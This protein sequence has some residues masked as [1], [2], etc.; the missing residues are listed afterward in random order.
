MHGYCV[1]K[2]RNGYALD[3]DETHRQSVVCNAQAKR[4]HVV[5]GCG[6]ESYAERRVVMHC[7]KMQRN[8][9]EMISTGDA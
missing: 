4:G 1:D 8:S 3:C 2:Y 5:R 7:I 6:S 9:S